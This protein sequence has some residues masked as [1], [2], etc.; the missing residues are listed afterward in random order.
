MSVIRTTGYEKTNHQ[1]KATVAGMF[2]EGTETGLNKQLSHCF[3]QAQTIEKPPALKLNQPVQGLIVPHAG[4]SFSGSVAA[5]AYQTLA[6]S[7]FADAFI[8]LGPNHQGLGAPV[9]LYPEGN[10]ETPLGTI[11]IDA[12][13]VSELT[14]DVIEID[15][16]AHQQRENSIEVQLPFLQ[17]F[18]KSFSFAPIAMAQQDYQTATAVG[19]QIA[20]V[21]QHENRRICIIASTDF[22]HEGLAYG[23]MQPKNLDVNAFTKEQDHYAID[24][25]LAHDP[26]RL[27][28]EIQRHQISM[29]G[30]GPVIAILTATKQLGAEN[31]FLLHYATSCDVITD[32]HACVGYGAF[33]VTKS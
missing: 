13:L 30:Y 29:C 4:L 21:I 26:K 20:T 22:S 9:A 10:W 11:P 8:V 24:A 14:S 16:H 27:V 32:A 15:D 7:G 6:E 2:Y 1:R 17:Y 23:R 5:I 12:P 19:E 25:I 18:N 3:Q 33:C 31:I 28:E